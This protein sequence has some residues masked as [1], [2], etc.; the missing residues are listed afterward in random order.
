MK[1]LFVSFAVVA[2]SVCQAFGQ[3]QYIPAK[4]P[5]DGNLY[6]VLQTKLSDDNLKG[7]VL[8]V[9]YTASEYKE[10]FGEP[11]EGQV[12]ERMTTFYDEAGTSFL[13]RKNDGSSAGESYLFSKE[14]VE[15]G[16][17]VT[18]IGVKSS[19]TGEDVNLM[20]AAM[21]KPDWSF[22]QM[23]QGSNWRYECENYEAVYDKNGV[24]IK[25]D[26]KDTSKEK[27]IKS[28]ELGKQT[29]NNVYEFVIYNAR[30]E[31]V[32]TSTRTY[33][34]GRLIKKSSPQD[35]FSRVNADIQS[36]MSGTY[37]YNQ[38]GRPVNFKKFNNQ[39]EEKYVYNAKGDL[40]NTSTKK[41]SGW[42]D[43]NFYENYKYD[44]QGNW[45]YRTWARE[46]G[47]P[48][49]IEKRV[50]VYCST[51]EELKE[52]AAEISQKAGDIIRNFKVE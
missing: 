46:K 13:S 25:L 50:I 35:R 49:R 29:G 43:G 23:L 17:K 38:A 33:S 39:E 5:F 2:A 4:L 41:Y 36:P 11:T 51:K 42:D 32:E 14:A 21:S 6:G 7:N 34:N 24:R 8:A 19:F 22:E 3:I 15:N 27:K 9:A 45:I 30:G 37:T 20:N 48:F 31:S 52:K 44:E 18:S 10:N 16:V 26:L 12:W 40:L 1:R 47:K 28:R